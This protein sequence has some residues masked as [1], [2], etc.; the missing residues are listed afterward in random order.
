MSDKFKAV[1]YDEVMEPMDSFTIHPD[2]MTKCWYTG[3]PTIALGTNL[4]GV[5]GKMFPTAETV[6][7][8]IPQCRMNR[9]AHSVYRRPGGHKLWNLVHCSHW[10]NLHVGAAYLPVKL[11]LRDH[12][13]K[14]CAGHEVFDMALQSRVKQDMNLILNEFKV[15]KQ[16]TFNYS[17]EYASQWEARGMLEKANTIHEK[18]IEWEIKTAYD[19]FGIKLR[20]LKFSKQN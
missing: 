16:Y 10:M 8:L 1:G 20:R 11:M 19:E 4:V 7:H 2:D 5:M 9:K 17:S 18:C 12:I 13:Q 15:G 6:E 3:L 14:L